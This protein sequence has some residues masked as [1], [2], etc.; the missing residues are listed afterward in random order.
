MAETDLVLS[1]ATMLRVPSL[2]H[3]L[4]RPAS[5]MFF[6]CFNFKSAKRLTSFFTLSNVDDV[7]SYD[8]CFLSSQFLYCWITEL[9]KIGCVSS[10][11][12]LCCG[13]VRN[14]CHFV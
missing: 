2:V 9:G 5:S 12:T 1:F 6:C 10:F 11:S 3:G 13:Q 8:S 7:L 14:Q 4:V